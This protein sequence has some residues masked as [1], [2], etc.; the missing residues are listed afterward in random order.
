MIPLLRIVLVEIATFSVMVFLV[1]VLYAFVFM[2]GLF[3]CSCRHP[4]ILNTHIPAFDTRVFRIHSDPCVFNS[5]TAQ[6]FK[7]YKL[8]KHNVSQK[9]QAIPWFSNVLQDSWLTN[10]CTIIK[11][12]IYFSQNTLTLKQRML[13]SSKM[14]IRMSSV[15]IKCF[16]TF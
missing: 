14:K 1:N 2:L 12:G 10:V 9:D 13:V 5:A 16:E 8:I 11:G 3:S 15:L 4:T 7:S 6:F